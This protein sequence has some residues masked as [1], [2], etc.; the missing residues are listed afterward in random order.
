MDAIAKATLQSIQMR[1]RSYV[2]FTFSPVVPIAGWLE[3]LDATLARSPGF[4]HGKPVVI[5]FQ[6]QIFANQPSF[7]SSQAWNNGTY[8][9]LASRA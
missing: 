7:T 6:P 2:V 9:S 8:V 3:E 1:G 4:F 5:D